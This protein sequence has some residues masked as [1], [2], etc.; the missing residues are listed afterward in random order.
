[1]KVPTAQFSTLPSITAQ[2]DTAGAFEQ[3][4]ALPGVEQLDLLDAERAVTIV[5]GAGD[6]RSLAT[7][8]LP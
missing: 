5:R 6:Q 1:V 2:V 7:P 4:A 3:I 8:L